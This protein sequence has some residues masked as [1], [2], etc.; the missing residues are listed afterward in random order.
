M[1]KSCGRRL[2]IPLK[3]NFDWRSETMSM[4]LL[5]G[6]CSL[7]LPFLA[8]A[9]SAQAGQLDQ[10]NLQTFTGLATWV[11]FQ[12]QV[13]AGIGGL[14]VGVELYTTL[15]P[16]GQNPGVAEL[17]T[18]SIGVGPGFFAGAFSFITQAWI[19][20]GGT[21]IDTSAAGIYLTP[22]ELFVIDVTDPQAGTCCNLGGAWRVYSGGDL[23]MKQG[24]TISE[25][26]GSPGT[27]MAFETFMDPNAAPP[28]PGTP[29]PGTLALFGSG[30]LG[31]AWMRRRKTG[32]D[33]LLSDV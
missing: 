25:D 12:Q 1:W 6:Q 23:F 9:G 11:E 13:T 29:E 26:S 8:L 33:G 14:L 24:S 31:V 18:V 3:H 16:P 21:Y 5:I 27:S 10:S 28:E 30:V 4:R 22:G 32:R 15:S 17:D 2:A 7:I 19:E 20:P